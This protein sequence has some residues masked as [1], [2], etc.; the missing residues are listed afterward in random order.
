MP[1]PMRLDRTMS[2]FIRDIDGRYK[3]YVDEGGSR[4]LYMGVW[5]VRAPQEGSI[6]VCGEC[7]PMV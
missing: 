3:K 1:V 5:R 6:W 2:D 7:G 4:R